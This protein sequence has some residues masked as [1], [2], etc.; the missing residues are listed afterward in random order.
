MN[1]FLS[2][3]YML[4]N[5]FKSKHIYLNDLDW[6][7]LYNSCSY[8]NKKGFDCFSSHMSY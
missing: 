5:G 8:A 6:T 4:L 2:V 3:V 7:T 1:I